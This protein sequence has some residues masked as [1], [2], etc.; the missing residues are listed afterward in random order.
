MIDFK[1]V[2]SSWS[3]VLIPP[4]PLIIYIDII[5]PIDNNYFGNRFA[6]FS[7]KLD[8]TWGLI[9]TD[10]KSYTLLIIKYKEV[11]CPHN[12]RMRRSIGV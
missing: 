3:Q 10:E 6:L 5:T 2:E 7:L 12:Q 8:N 9:F 1:Q 4:L 11:A